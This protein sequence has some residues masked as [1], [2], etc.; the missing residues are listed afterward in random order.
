MIHVLD[1][2]STVYWYIGGS[3]RKLNSHIGADEDGK[4][5]RKF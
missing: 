2:C 1:E 5:L 4:V 3:K